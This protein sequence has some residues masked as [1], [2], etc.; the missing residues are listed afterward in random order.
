MKRF[1]NTVLK[2]SFL[3]LAVIGMLS[4]S[5]CDDDDPAVDPLV[6]KYRLTNA[7]TA[8]E[9]TIVL[10]GATDPT[11]LPNGSDVTSIIASI[12]AAASPCEN[13]AN[14]AIELA[15][16]GTFYYTCN[17]ED[18]DRVD[19]GEW[20]ADATSNSVTLT[21]QSESLGQ[22]I[23]VVVSDYTVV[24]TSFSGLIEGFPVPI[25]INQPFGAPLEGTSTPN[26]QFASV[27]ATFTKI[28]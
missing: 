22:T 19:S 12:L 15:E 8:A 18:V 25:D 28:P 27:D 16:G 23:T 14:A 21:I 3:S 24:S 6:G 17:G 2:F 1:F 26:F 10:P 20:S 4:V 13:P 11:T 5:G 9:L 7:T